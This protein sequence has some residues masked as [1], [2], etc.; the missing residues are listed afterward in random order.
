M[1]GHDKTRTQPIAQTGRD[2]SSFS[3]QSDRPAAFLPWLNSCQSYGQSHHERSCCTIQLFAP[4]IACGQ[5]R[6]GKLSVRR[7][8]TNFLGCARRRHE[9]W[10]GHSM[11]S[12][13]RPCVPTRHEISSCYPQSWRCPSF[14]RCCHGTSSACQPFWPFPRCDP[15]RLAGYF[16]RPLS[17]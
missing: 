14:A 3:T 8:L 4:C 12:P 6:R 17:L 7:I 13:S 16:A 15:M 11:S 2:L 10:S 1:P 5:R 9:R